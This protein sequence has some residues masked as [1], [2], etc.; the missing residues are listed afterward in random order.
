MAR[1][2][3]EEWYGPRGSDMSTGEALWR[4]T[5]LARKAIDKDPRN[6]QA[7]DI[8]EALGVGSY[9]GTYKEPKARKA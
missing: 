9:N 6:T 8:I 3:Q 2:K 7:I 5:C 1:K 4:V